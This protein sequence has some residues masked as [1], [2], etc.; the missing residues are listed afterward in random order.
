MNFLNPAWLWGLLALAI[1][2]IVHLFNFRKTRRVYFS[3]TRFIKKVRESSRSRRKLKHY[4]VLMSRL[5]FI[6]WLVMAFAQPFIPA[7]QGALQKER[8]YF[9]LDN[10]YSMSRISGEQMTAFEE[11]IEYISHLISLYPTGT[12]FFLLTND[13]A[14]FSH[15]PHSAKEFSE[16][17]TEVKYSGVIR[18]ADEVIDRWESQ[19]VMNGGGD[20]YFISDFQKSTVMPANVDERD[21]TFEL[22]L[23]PIKSEQ[24]ANV[25]IDTVYLDN[26]FL[27]GKERLTLHV[28]LKNDAD[29][30]SNELSVTIHLDNV[31]VASTTTDIPA[32]GN[33][34]LDFDLMIDP[35]AG[36]L[37]RVSIEEYPVTFDNDLYFVLSLGERINI[38]E[39]KPSD[40]RTPVSRVFGNKNLFNF[41]GYNYRN[42]DYNI[43]ENADLLVMNGLKEIN[44]SLSGAIVSYLQKG[45]HVMLIP[46]DDP[47]IASYRNIF[48][49]IS[50]S[51]T[52]RSK[53]LAPDFNHPFFEQVFEE[54]DP[55]VN[56]PEASSVITWS[57]AGSILRLSN[58][59]PFLSVVDENVFLLSSPLEDKFTD[60]HRH[61]LFVPVM[62]K[63]AALSTSQGQSLYHYL[64]ER[65]LTFAVDSV[66]ASQMFKLVKEQEEIIPAQRVLNQRL[67]LQLPAYIVNTG[68]YRLMNEGRTFETIAFN[69]N[70]EESKLKTLSDQEIESLR[71]FYP[72][73]SIY[74][75]DNVDDF[76]KKLEEQYIGWPLWKYCLILA[77]LF[78]LAEILIIRFVP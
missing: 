39:V 42:L 17:L 34:T 28:K 23:L 67:L 13:F 20:Y 36:K 52:A 49:R 5:L 14:P 72:G 48:G 2:V 78:L 19:Q 11:G 62:Y 9:Y 7:S 12:D 1:P 35:S 10:S 71:G 57:G 77:I 22:R 68:Y 33:K 56:M 29:I 75:V 31:Q 27:I 4:L 59:K 46:D 15:A 41:N 65:L 43:L 76:R 30:E 25:Y 51:D 24:D 6:F 58:G 8:V 55:A 3:N 45:G 50:L 32:D 40:D 70:K 73:M 44:T 38:V 53:V 63:I 54:K 74:N 26:P 37:G 61:A 69:I 18:N 60:M 47:V 21:S 16:L 64:D 66:P